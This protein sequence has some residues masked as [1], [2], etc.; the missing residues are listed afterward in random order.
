MADARIIPLENGY[1]ASVFVVLEQDGQLIDDPNRRREIRDRL[2]QAVDT[3]D[4]GSYRVTRRAPRQVRMFSTPILVTFDQDETNKR[5]VM[6]L[7]AGDRPGLLSQVGQVLREHNVTIETAKIV[8]VG[9]R[10][11]DVFYVTD[12]EGKQLTQESCDALLAQ[13]TSTLDRPA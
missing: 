9:E 10:A 5:T 1:G 11:E 8:T 7:V 13:L 3:P 12:T 6:E 2:A 4:F